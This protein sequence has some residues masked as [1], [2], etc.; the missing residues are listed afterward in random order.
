MALILLI[1]DDAGVSRFVRLALD[2]EPW[3]LEHVTTLAA[4]RERLARTPAPD[5]VLLDLMLPDG[6]GAELLEDDALRIALP[7][8]AW[9]L[10]SAG[11][12]GTL[13][14]EP[15]RVR[16]WQVW[17]VLEKPVSVVALVEALREAVGAR[18]A[19]AD[20][21][22]G[23]G[24]GS[25]DGE[26]GGP[27]DAGPGHAGPGDTGPPDGEPADGSPQA[28]AA[29]I[30]RHF[31]GRR[32]LFE[33]MRAFSAPR[34]VQDLERLQGLVTRLVDGD[35]SDATLRREVQREAHSLKTVLALLGRPR[36]A[37]AAGRLEGVALG[38][39]VA[40]VWG[41]WVG[42]AGHAAGGLT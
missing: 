40:G 9:L 32:E 19:G 2:D 18:S 11:R 14:R 4:A 42:L 12:A 38:E 15:E 13:A 41:A 8:T 30:E 20:A 22:G 17:R 31:D 5:A 6:S 35:G 1:E 37:E 3:A 27:G 16:G 39:P 26:A 34:V 23:D 25:G 28:E 36:A 10:F 24:G 21:R 7:D 29:A 33:Q